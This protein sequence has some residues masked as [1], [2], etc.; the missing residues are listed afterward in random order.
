[1][2][3]IVDGLEVGFR[4]EVITDISEHERLFT[5]EQDI[6]RRA[7]LWGGDPLDVMDLQGE[8]I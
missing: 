7:T 5:A 1:M 8:V 2:R 4:G 6:I 3:D